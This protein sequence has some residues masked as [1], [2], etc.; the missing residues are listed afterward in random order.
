M[1]AQGEYVGP[2][3][4][5][6]VPEYRVRTDDV[7][8]F[9]FRLTAEPSARRYRLQPGDQLRF[10][11]M[12][13]PEYSR[14]WVVVEPDGYI[15]FPFGQVYA[16]G[17]TF[18]ELRET[19]QKRLLDEGIREPKVVVAPAVAGNKP[20]INTR[21]EEL[22]NTVDAR[23]AVTGG[24]TTRARVTP[25]GTIQLP[26]IGSVPATGLT[27]LELEREIEH[28]YAEIVDGIE[29]TPALFERAPRY[30][31]VLG[32]VRAPGRYT[33]EGP[34]TVMQAITL[35]GSW[36]VG[37][38]LKEIV[39]FRRDDNWNLMATK[40]NIHAALF[41]KRPCPADEIW[42]RDND[43]VLVPQSPILMTDNFIDLVFTRGIYG[44]VPFGTTLSWSSLSNRTIVR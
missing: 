2:H 44:V 28:R 6:H 13:A 34:T 31:Y 30:V 42:I 16:A 20:T 14:D 43:I 40:L 8:E 18:E 41:G 3:R 27:L 15:S 21:L 36:N 37:A 19:L 22:R 33:L 11:S 35:A 24:Q 12:S 9:V 39:V 26:A 7:L 5:P 10:D 23:E 17:L 1:F 4:L 25:E 32:E 38:H 29:I